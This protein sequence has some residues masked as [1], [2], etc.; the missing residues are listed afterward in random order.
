[1]KLREVILNCHQYVDTDDL[2]HMVF[3][4]KTNDKFDPQ[5]EAKVLALTRD[6]MEMNLTDIQNSKCPRYDYFL[7]INIIQDFSDDIRN[8]EEFKS[9]DD[10]VKR[11]IYYAEFD[12]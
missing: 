12:A 1:M 9:D 2:I 4:K 10:K 7:E 3:A 8:L 5:G 6:K 11:I